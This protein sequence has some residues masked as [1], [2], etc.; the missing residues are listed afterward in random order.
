MP[1]LQRLQPLPRPIARM[2][3]HHG[4]ASRQAG[5][6]DRHLSMPTCVRLAASAPAP[7]VVN[8]LPQPGKAGDRHRHAAAAGRCH[9]ASSS[10]PN[11]RDSEPKPG[12]MTKLVVF[13]CDK[14]VDVRGLANLD[15]A[16]ISLICTGML[17]PSFIEYALRAASM[18]SS[19]PAVARRL[20]FPPRHAMDAGA[21]CRPAANRICRSLVRRSGCNWFLHPAARANNSP[22]P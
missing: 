17:P 22:S 7:A 19:S 8:T 9:N 2:S 18:V 16:A 14:G 13:G 3:R 5:A 11:W 21:P 15:T 1:P 12:G 4:G 10:K 20:R 6:Q